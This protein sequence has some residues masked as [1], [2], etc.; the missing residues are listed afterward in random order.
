[1]GK[2]TLHQ[3]LCVSGGMTAMSKKTVKRR[4]V[5]FAKSRKRLLTRDLRVELPGTKHHG[6]MRRLER[7]T[8][9]LQSSRNCFRGN[10]A[11][12]TRPVFAS[13]KSAAV[14]QCHLA[15]VCGRNAGAEPPYRADSA[16][17]CSRLVEVE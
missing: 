3:V 5:C 11:W 17:I 16:G 13:I 1:M 7:S 9:F 6:P 15:G 10:R 12:R 8:A 2:K 4:P 14:R